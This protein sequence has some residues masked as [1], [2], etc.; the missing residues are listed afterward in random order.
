MQPSVG[1]KEILNANISCAFQSAAHLTFTATLRWYP[2]FISGSDKFALIQM[3]SL[4]PLFTGLTTDVILQVKC[5]SLDSPKSLG[6]FIAY[7][8]CFAMMGDTTWVFCC[9]GRGLPAPRLVA[10]LNCDIFM[11][12]FGLADYFKFMYKDTSLLCPCYHL[13]RKLIL[14]EGLLPPFPP[15]WDKGIL[16]LV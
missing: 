14:L 8:W 13:F 5:N 10:L 16:L 1:C 2:L 6:L 11:V 7:T 4:S 3:E 12:C 9:T 15:S